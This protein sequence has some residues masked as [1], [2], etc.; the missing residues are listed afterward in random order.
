MGVLSTAAFLLLLPSCGNNGGAPPAPPPPE[1]AVITIAPVALARQVDLPARVAPVRTAEVRARVDGIVEERLFVEGTDVGRGTPLFRIDSRP[2]RASLDVQTATVRRAEAEAA[3]AQREVARF[4]PLVPRGAISRQEYEAAQARLARAR[5]DVGSAQAQVRQAQLTLGYTTVT[6]P[7][8]GRV[9]RAEATEG[10]L[11]SQASGTLLTRIEQLDPIYV[12]FAVTSDDLMALRRAEMGGAP[13]ISRTV[14]LLLPDGSD[15]GM[16]G[17]LN[18][19]DQ[20]VDPSTGTVG[21]RATF[22]NPLRLLLPGQFV[23]VRIEAGTDPNGISVPQ[24]AVQMTTGGGSVMVVGAGNIPVVRPVTLARLAG[25]NWVV[26]KGLS[27]GERVIVD[28]LQQVRPGAPVK[29]VPL[30][31]PRAPVRAAGG[32]TNAR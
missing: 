15:Y 30:G 23:R 3:N 19:L 1:V 10:A 7:I 2:L 4:A 29:P 5:A 18:F 17:T 20:S 27:P 16:T 31:A 26:T 28:G 25:G 32:A 6:A 11:A 12:N 8:A 21:V 24:R 13:P 14:M 22:R 9:G